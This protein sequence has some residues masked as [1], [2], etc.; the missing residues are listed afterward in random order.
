MYL[1][2]K[3]SKLG[4]MLGSRQ[5]YGW[6]SS[7]NTRKLQKFYDLTCSTG[8]QDDFVL[9][10]EDCSKSNCFGDWDYTGKTKHGFR[11]FELTKRDDSL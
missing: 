4:V 7:F 11:V 6:C 10:M 5:G 1:L 9:A 2:H 3:P 8:N